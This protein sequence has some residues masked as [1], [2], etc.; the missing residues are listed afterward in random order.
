[1]TSRQAPDT[2]N[3]R[4]GVR[5]LGCQ[6]GS[7]AHA[8]GRRPPASAPYRR[9]DRLGVPCVTLIRNRRWTVESAAFTQ[10]LYNL[11]NRGEPPPRNLL[12]ALWKGREY[13]RFRYFSHP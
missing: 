13:Y 3:P 10:D 11:V 7:R 2:G 9:S 1:M 5:K 6:C 12:P 4:P 8:A